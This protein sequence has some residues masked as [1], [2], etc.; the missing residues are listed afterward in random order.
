M[1]L[2]PLK[3]WTCGSEKN[4][5][6]EDI[7]SDRSIRTNERLFKLGSRLSAGRHVQQ[8]R[9]PLQPWL[10]KTSVRVIYPWDR[11][12]TDQTGPD[13]FISLDCCLLSSKLGPVWKTQSTSVPSS[14]PGPGLDPRPH[15]TRRPDHSTATLPSSLCSKLLDVD[16][17]TL[18]GCLNRTDQN[19]IVS[20]LNYT[21]MKELDWLSSVPWCSLKTRIWGKSLQLWSAWTLDRNNP[22]TPPPYLPWCSIDAPGMFSEVRGHGWPSKKKNKKASMTTMLESSEKINVSQTGCLS[23]NHLSPSLL[24]L[25]AANLLDSSSL[26]SVGNPPGRRR[27]KKTLGAKKHVSLFTY[28]LQVW[29]CVCVF[30]DMCV[31]VL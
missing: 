26:P 9:S 18:S 24:V 31:C 2:R 7:N 5:T 21:R 30:I 28:S 13:L 19:R 11:T 22:L 14:D 16:L 3:T 12:G 4:E 8:T 29:A 10:C 1:Q 15:Y 6:S 17:W 23:V 20:S 25:L 27:K